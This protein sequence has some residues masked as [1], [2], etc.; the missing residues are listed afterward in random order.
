[1][2]RRPGFRLTQGDRE[3]T[4]AAAHV[5]Q[6]LGGAQRNPTG[7]DARRG[8]RAR[9]LGRGERT[10]LRR[11]RHQPA[12]GVE[13]D[14]GAG[15]PDV[16][17]HERRVDLPGDLQTEVLAEVTG[18][19]PHQVELRRRRVP[20]ARPVGDEKTERGQRVQERPQPVRRYAGRR[21]QSRDI[22]RSVGEQAEQVDLQSGEQRLGGHEPVGDVGQVA[23]L[24]RG[25]GG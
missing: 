20:V 14:A 16:E 15:E 8:E 7:Q 25:Q 19:T 21:R 22:A 4:A 6:P 9:V 24:G 12:E 11:L 1:V 17:V 2:A 23:T 10:G 13:C 3:R 18:C 5:E